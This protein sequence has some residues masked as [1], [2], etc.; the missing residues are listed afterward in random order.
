[1]RDLSRLGSRHGTYV[2]RDNAPS[3]WPCAPD[4]GVAERPGERLATKSAAH[5]HPHTDHRNASKSPND[6]LA[7][8]ESRDSHHS[9]AMRREIVG[10]RVDGAIGTSENER[11]V[12][13]AVDFRNIAREL[14]SPERCFAREQGIVRDREAVHERIIGLGSAR[15]QVLPAGVTGITPYALPLFSWSRR[16]GSAGARSEPARMPSPFPSFD[17]RLPC[18]LGSRL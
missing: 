12:D 16:I 14:R 4:A 11:L 15:A 7:R 13:E 3:L 10:L 1:M 9:G 8:L 17:V 18:T 2:S 6:L 5:V